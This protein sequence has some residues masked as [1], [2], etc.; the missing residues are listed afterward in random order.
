MNTPHPQIATTEGRM[1]TKAG[2]ALTIGNSFL[3]SRL[4]TVGPGSININ[5]ETIRETGNELTVAVVRDVPDL[6]FDLESLDCTIDTEAGICNI[7]PESLNDGDMLHFGMAKAY[8]VVGPMKAAGTSK[9]TDSGHIWAYLALESAAYRFGVQSNATQNFSFRG[10]NQYAAMQTPYREVF[11][12]DGTETEFAFANTAIKTVEKGE[13]IYGLSVCIYKSD[14]TYVRLFHGEDYTD[15]NA[16]IELTVAAPNG[17]TVAVCYFSATPAVF[18]QTVHPTASV[19][20]GAVK[21]QDINLYVA[22]GPQRT[23][24]INTTDTSTSIVGVGSAFTSADIGARIVSDNVPE[25]TTITAVADATH[26][27]I[28][29]AADATATGTVTTLNPPLIRWDGV[30]EVQINWRV[31]LD[32]D[33][34]LGNAHI[35]DADYD[36]PEVSGSITLRPASNAKL[37][38]KIAQASGANPAEVS[39]LLASNPLEMRVVICHPDTGDELKTFQVDAARIVSPTTQARAGQKIEPQFQ[40]SDDTGLLK[41]YKGAIAA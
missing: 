2:K 6:S 16:G 39:N 22:V 7:D 33:R 19:K 10:D 12:G 5:S 30:Q 32:Q 31:Q 21:G 38:A 24:T 28:S 26:A 36:T 17:S 41:I 1:S 20:P 14:G 8:D 37:H 13:D 34:E 35:I 40:W 9:T 29:D 15:D 11:D 3:V 23:F 18:A 25:G 4:Q 27:T